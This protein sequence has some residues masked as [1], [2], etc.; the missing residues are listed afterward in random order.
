MKWRDGSAF[1]S[2]ESS[3]CK[4]GR[5]PRTFPRYWRVAEVEPPLF[6][7]ALARDG[8]LPM[9]RRGRATLLHLTHQF[10]AF[11]GVG[12]VATMVHYG[13][14][15]T[16]V[17]AVR[18]APVPATLVGYV[19]GGLVSYP[20]N[21]RLTYVSNRPHR[22]A[23]WRFAAVALVGFGLTGVLMQALT[24]WLGAPYLPAQ[25]VTT[26]IVLFWSFLANRIWTFRD[27]SS[28]I[29]TQ[30]KYLKN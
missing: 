8:I 2:A 10:V 12:V 27:S 20:L 24:A 21:R 4:R 17:E 5:D 16:L 19:A 28:V 6:D 26:G 7:A 3:P 18:W 14:L 9:L 13:F 30:D 23:T 15:I 22:Q 11:F 25:V 1:G 29:S